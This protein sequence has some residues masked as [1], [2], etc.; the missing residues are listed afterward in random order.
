[1]IGDLFGGPNGWPWFMLAWF[2][3]W[4]LLTGWAAARR[5]RNRWAWALAG[6]V[7]AWVALLIVLILG[8]ARRWPGG[9]PEPSRDEVSQMLRDHVMDNQ[10]SFPA[11]DGCD[12]IEADGTCWTSSAPR[13]RR[14][15]TSSRRRGGTACAAA[16]T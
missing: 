5:R 6:L 1:M 4:A 8:P 13:A 11:T 15:W 2:G 16:R 14:A 10:V 12:G 9:A 7:G 3:G